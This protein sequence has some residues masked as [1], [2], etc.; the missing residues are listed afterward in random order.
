MVEEGWISDDIT[1]QI[2]HRY[3]DELIDKGIDALVLGCTHYPMLA[4]EIKKVTGDN[5]T[6][7]NPAFECAREFRYLLEENG[8]L[9][10]VSQE[11]GHE[12]YVSDGPKA[13]A[14]LAESFLGEDIVTRAN[15]KVYNFENDD[16][17]LRTYEIKR[18][19]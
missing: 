7:V 17:I 1:R 3:L 9:C 12:F 11:L 16:S 5:I 13:F 14:E 6:L 2:I 4:D 15:V 8:L 19:V 10:E 18:S